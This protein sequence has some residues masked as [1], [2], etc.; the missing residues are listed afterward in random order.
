MVPVVFQGQSPGGVVVSDMK[1]A[2]SQFVQ[3]A[4]WQKS[5]DFKHPCERSAMP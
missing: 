4:K 2:A 5:T 3:S 1:G